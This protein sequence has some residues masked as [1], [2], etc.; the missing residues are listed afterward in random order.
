VVVVSVVKGIT[1]GFEIVVVSV[2]G[3]L[4]AIVL[5]PE[6]FNGVIVTGE[7]AGVSIVPG[8]MALV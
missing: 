2:I 1:G 3:G 6:V 5:V 8:I 4:I 7:T